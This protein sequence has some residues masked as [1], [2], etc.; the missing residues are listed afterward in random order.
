MGSLFYRIM[1]NKPVKRFYWQK[2]IHSELTPKSKS[3]IGVDES[4]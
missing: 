2:G 4:R 3:K 1:E